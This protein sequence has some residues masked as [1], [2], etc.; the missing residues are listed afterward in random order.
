MPEQALMD[1][2]R[3]LGGL[4]GVPGKQATHTVQVRLLTNDVAHDEPHTAQATDL[5]RGGMRLQLEHA[6]P[7]GTLL[8]VEFP[9]ITTVLATVIHADA[10]TSTLSCVFTTE[11]GDEHL[12]IFGARQER[13][14]GRD[15]R[16]WVRFPCNAK[17][18]YH[19][20]ADA[21][22]SER[23]GRIINISPSGI[24]LLVNH[25]VTAG[26]LLGMRLLDKNGQHAF[27]LLA[28]VLHVAPQAEGESALGCVFIRELSTDEF[29]ELEE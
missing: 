19:V 11:L 21:D 20:I 13:A 27:L 17:A 3:L 16:R 29:Q 5:S 8:S 14:S 25:S 1:L 15:K 4:Q 24:G 26:T 18:Y 10:A 22:P 12:T 28:C 23:V 6:C 9:G 7:A 2:G